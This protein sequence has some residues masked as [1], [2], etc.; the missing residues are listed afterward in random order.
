[1]LLALMIA[2]TALLLAAFI[3]DMVFPFNKKIWTSSFV[4]LTVGLDLLIL[5][6][7]IYIVEI[8]HKHK[9]TYFFVVFGRNPLFIYLL[10]DV[11]IT[12]MSLI[13]VGKTN[14]Q[15]WLYKD[16]FGSFT[17]PTLASFLFA[18]FFMLLNWVI[19]YVLDRRRI[20]IKV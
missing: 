2:G 9:W 15:Q 4:L 12:V 16:V 6:V 1:M 3:W 20:Y 13:V 14:L 5:S 7:L 10:A 19:G 8:Y 18:V 11:L 17:G